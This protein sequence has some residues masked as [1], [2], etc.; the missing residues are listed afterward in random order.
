MRQNLMA[1]VKEY[2]QYLCGECWRWR[3]ETRTECH[4]C[5]KGEWKLKESC[6]GYLGQ[7]DKASIEEYGIK[8]DSGSAARFFYCAKAPR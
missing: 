4:A 8:F 7:P 2:D 5:G 1:E 6:G 3:Y